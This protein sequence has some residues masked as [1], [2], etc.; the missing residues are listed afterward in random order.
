MTLLRSL[1]FNLFYFTSTA[2]LLIPGIAVW[3][4]FPSRS[5]ALATLWARVELAAARL[6]CGIKLDV[7]GREHLP[8]GAALIASRHESAFDTLVWLLLVPRPSYVMKQELTRIPI[9]GGMVRPAG[10][11]P[12]DRDGGGAAMRALMRAGADAAKAGRQI[13][14]FPEGTRMDPGRDVE[15]QPGIAAL[16]AATRLPVIPVVTDSGSY[17][18]R[19]AFRKRPGTIRIVILP[20]LPAGLARGALMDG[21]GDAMRTGM[22]ALRP[23]GT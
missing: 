9:F 7:T 19:R 20:P 1:L 6:I 16:A 18:G 15:L 14:I 22:A 17:W 8:Q 2:V 13:I 5:L 4:F 23:G 12:V 3:L 11:I 21:L 10:M